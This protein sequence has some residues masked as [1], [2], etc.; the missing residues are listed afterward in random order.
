MGSDVMPAAVEIAATPKEDLDNVATTPL[1]AASAPQE[2]V[3]VPHYL[4]TSLPHY[5]APEVAMADD[6]TPMAGETMSAQGEA[7]VED[8]PK[9]KKKKKKK[10]KAAEEAEA[11][12]AAAAADAAAEEE[13]KAGQWKT[14]AVAS[15]ADDAAIV[16]AA[17]EVAAEVV[18]VGQK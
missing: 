10:G 3:V 6:E 2:A 8:K 18:A 11:A 1:N 4:A 17:K 5:L 16:E 12:A 7:E 14:E 13:S 9:K 15:L